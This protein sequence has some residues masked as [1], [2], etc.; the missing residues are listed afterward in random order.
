MAEEAIRTPIAEAH[1]AV[2]LTAPALTVV[3]PPA[4]VASVKILPDRI[5][6]ANPMIELTYHVWLKHAAPHIQ[7]AILTPDRTVVAHGMI[8]IEEFRLSIPVEGA[9]F[10]T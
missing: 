3:A 5:E 6:F 8:V 10:R 7:T 4:R 2:E 9:R 1:S